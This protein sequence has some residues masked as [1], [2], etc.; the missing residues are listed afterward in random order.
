MQG[1]GNL[2]EVTVSFSNFPEGLTGAITPEGKLTLSGSLNV[3]DENGGNIL[4]GTVQVRSWETT[5]SG[6]DDMGGGWTE[7]YAWVMGRI[8]TA[9]TVDELVTLHRSTSTVAQPGR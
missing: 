6:L 8:G 2:S 1:G 4:L 3:W 5:L 7:D 9:H